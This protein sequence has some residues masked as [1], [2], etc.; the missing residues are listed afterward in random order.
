VCEKISK[1]GKRK[2]Q[3]AADNK[4]G[5]GRNHTPLP[6]TPQASKKT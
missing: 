4:K 3:T 1:K 5:G 2:R 6:T